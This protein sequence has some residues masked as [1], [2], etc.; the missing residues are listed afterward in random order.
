MA[1]VG[2]IDRCSF[3][4]GEIHAIMELFNSQGRVDTVAI[5]IRNSGIGCQREFE[6]TTVKCTQARTNIKINGV[7]TVYG[8]PIF[9]S[10]RLAYSV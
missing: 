6:Y 7:I 8:I 4:C 2:C 3:R 10:N 9:G 5:I 1:V